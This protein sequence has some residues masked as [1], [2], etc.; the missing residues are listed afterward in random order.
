MSNQAMK[1]HGGSLDVYYC[2]RNPSEKAMCCMITTTRHS[3]KGK[4]MDTV[5][6]SGYQGLRERKDEYRGSLGQ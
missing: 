5:K 3:E 1:R 6:I 2:E 4:A